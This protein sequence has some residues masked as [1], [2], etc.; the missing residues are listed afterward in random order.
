MNARIQLVESLLVV[1]VAMVV[2]VGKG[3]CAEWQVIVDSE[4]MM[5]VI[6]GSV[7]WLIESCD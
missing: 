5:F 7:R 2:G 3:E 4:G 6:V 1:V